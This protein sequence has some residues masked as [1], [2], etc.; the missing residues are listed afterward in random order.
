MKR[1]MVKYL[2]PNCGKVFKDTPM[3]SAFMGQV[4]LCP[5]CGLRCD[6]KY[7][8]VANHY[9]L[10]NLWR[11]VKF[12]GSAVAFLA[13]TA[14]VLTSTPFGWAGAGAGAVAAA[15]IN[16]ISA[17]RKDRKASARMHN[18][19]DMQ[20]RELKAQAA[21]QRAPIQGLAP[22]YEESVPRLSQP[23][24]VDYEDDEGGFLPSRQ[25]PFTRT[26]AP[27]ARTEP[28]GAEQGGFEEGGFLQQRE[29][30]GG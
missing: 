19:M 2:C 4:S 27:A 11:G 25:R 26:P 28:F 15:V 6:E 22:T 21:A 8:Y 1:S 12:T 16:N 5:G 3:G 18:Q 7:R 30:F 13:V 10:R 24:D 9:I 20:I 29:F 23:G 14:A 17:R